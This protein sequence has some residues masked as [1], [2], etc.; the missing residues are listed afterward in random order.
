M[1]RGPEAWPVADAPQLRVGMIQSN[2]IPRLGSFDF[3]DDRDPVPSCCKALATDE[4]C[5]NCDRV[6]STISDP[7]PRVEASDGRQTLLQHATTAYDACWVRHHV[8]RR[9][10]DGHLEPWEFEVE[11]GQ[12]DGSLAH[13]VARLLTATVAEAGF[14][15]AQ[16]V[17]VP[18]PAPAPAPPHAR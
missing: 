2:D 14:E 15:V 4:N 16:T 10:R 1:A 18:Q 12:L 8:H 3:I 7:R 13:A 6:N 5:G 11:A 17:P 9:S